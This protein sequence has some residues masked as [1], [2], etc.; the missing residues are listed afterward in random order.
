MAGAELS[1][2]LVDPT[3]LS[4]VSLLAATQWA[5]FGW[6]RDSVGM[7]DSALSKQVTT[8]SKPGYIDVRKGYVGK[9]P[10]T[11]LSLSDSGR[12]ALEAHIAALHEIV[13]QSRQAGE[14][15][16]AHSGEPPS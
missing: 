12:S 10:R 15:Q 13:E 2:L 1:P 9:R 8:L 4:I 14:T 3:R 16:Q 5:E 11:W 6:V 7:S